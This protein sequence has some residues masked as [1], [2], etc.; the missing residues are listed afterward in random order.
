MTVPGPDSA[1]LGG[2]LAKKPSKNFEKCTKIV[3]SGTGLEIDVSRASRALVKTPGAE[4]YGEEAHNG[5][6]SKL[7][8]F[9][10]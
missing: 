2:R 4:K 5:P 3:D 9:G 8:Q 1:A 7:P 6:G 10:A